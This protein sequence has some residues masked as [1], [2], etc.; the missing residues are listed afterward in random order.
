[1]DESAT[2][3]AATLA[4]VFPLSVI[5]AKA[6]ISLPYYVPVEVPDPRIRKGRFQLS[7]E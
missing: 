6:G 7:L 4:E 2:E 3:R 5:P 1:V